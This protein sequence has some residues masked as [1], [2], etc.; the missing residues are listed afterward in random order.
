M[1]PKKFLTATDIL[2]QFGVDEATIQQLVE[3]GDLKALAD[4]GT[5]RYRREDIEA[6]VSSGRLHATRELEAVDDI[7]FDESIGFASESEPSAFADFL[8]LDEDALSGQSTVIS[9]GPLPDN[10]DLQLSFTEDPAQSS[11]DVNVIEPGDEIRSDSDIQL[12]DPAAGVA[13]PG[14]VT[15][16]EGDISD[17]D[18]VLDSD[19]V[20][21]SDVELIDE[22]AGH[23]SASDVTFFEGDQLSVSSDDLSISDVS[24]QTGELSSPDDFVDPVEATLAEEL[25]D[26][27]VSDSDVTTSLPDD[28]AG[29]LAATEEFNAGDFNFGD[30][31]PPRIEDF[32][33]AEETSALADEDD[34]LDFTADDSGLA[35]EPGES[36]LPLAA[37]DEDLALDAGD[38]G[39][40]LDT[41]DSGLTLEAGDSGLTLDSGD[42]GLTLDTGD[43]GLTLELVPDDAEP[44]PLA[45][46]TQRMEQ[47]V[48][49]DDELDFDSGSGDSAGT[50]RMAVEEQFEEELAFVDDEDSGQTAVFVTGEESGDDYVGTLS[51]A[52]DAGEEVEELE[53]ADDLSAALDDDDVETLGGD[54]DDILDAEDSAFSDE[55]SGEMDAEEDDESY[56]TPSAKSQPREPSWGVFPSVLVVA[57]SLIVGVN[58]W[59]M[60]E[61]LSTMWT[62][63][64]PSGAAASLI[65]TISGMLG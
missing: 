2:A 27:A 53:I 21:S 62:G 49:D 57:A 17:S 38:S 7:D 10:S 47:L 42:S 63:S 33:F 65:S 11:S 14:A 32:V 1:S 16:P 52:I 22:A 5:W 55:F 18:I 50:R 28:V 23:D 43:S 35:L 45:A 30:E 6:L 13:G 37:A 19:A 29:E 44:S 64:E 3:S 9:S 12:R 59:L 36:G 25:L 34:Q 20:S 15:V 54:E 4:R 46:G 41:G 51:G 48:G 39:L 60:W 24:D 26:D 31:A 56:L 58:A 40:T 61:G 8:E